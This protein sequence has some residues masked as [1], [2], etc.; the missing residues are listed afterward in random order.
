MS[1]S[2]A[3]VTYGL[4]FCMFRSLCFT[5]FILVVVISN[6][7]AQD[8]CD[9]AVGKARM[10]F[11]TG[12]LAEIIEQLPPCLEGEV[13]KTQKIYAY[14]ILALTYIAE[15]QPH[16]AKESV[17]ELLKIDYKYDAKNYDHPAQYSDEFKRYVDDVREVL[18]N[19]EGRK[20]AFFFIG[21]A[22]LAAGTAVF[23]WMLLL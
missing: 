18:P 19:P 20:R 1:K 4:S 2:H 7:R 13:S 21:G 5:I 6:L 8:N 23:L 12:H 22:G 16:K 17:T 11:E 9:H 3:K 15:D 14:Q 10:N